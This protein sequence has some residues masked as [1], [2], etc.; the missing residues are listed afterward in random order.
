MAVTLKDYTK[1]AP[2]VYKH[3]AD[4]RAKLPKQRWLINTRINGKPIRKVFTLSPD[5]P[6][7]MKLQ[8]I[9][10]L[11][12]F[13]KE[14]SK[15]LPESGSVDFYFTKWEK[16]KSNWCDAHRTSMKLYYKN[17]I[18]AAIGDKPIRD[19]TTMDITDIL[20]VDATLRT[21]KNITEILFPLFKYALDNNLIP[22]S[23]IIS[24]HKVVRN[25][26]REKRKVTEALVKYKKV[27]KAILELDTEDRAL[28]LFGF[29][30]RRKTEVLSLRW[31]DIQ[32]STYIVRRES[33]KVDEDM[34]YALPSDLIQVL[35]ELKEICNGTGYI[36]ESPKDP[37]KR[38][39]DIRKPVAK[40]RERSGIKE[41]GYHWMRNLAV[42]ALSQRGTSTVDL[43]AMLGHSDL[44]TLRKY[45]SFEREEST[46]RTTAAAMD[47]LK[48][49]KK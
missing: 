26:L 22:E 49:E 10:E 42:T 24:S 37:T 41:F 46:Q 4:A 40:I 20:S 3:K 47:F 29:H 12:K 17:H 23:P 19:V 16:S 33:N 45:L 8:A 32:N 35:E 48:E 30:G 43:S 5:T 1:I 13:K 27:Y 28:M 44:N 21:K 18:K 7:N 9:A 11:M 31:E 39:T 36:F 15:L 14:R 2:G 25:S 34:V 6:T 38:M